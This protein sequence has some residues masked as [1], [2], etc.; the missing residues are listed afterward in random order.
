MDEATEMSFL[1]W[2]QSVSQPLH[3]YDDFLTYTH[4]NRQTQ[5]QLVNRGR[6][7]TWFMIYS[8]TCN[9][10]IVQLMSEMFNLQYK[11]VS[12]RLTW[13]EVGEM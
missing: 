9:V 2:L 6:N 7:K 11:C 12:S 13:S 1:P 5:W 8:K 4:T 10:N 3:K